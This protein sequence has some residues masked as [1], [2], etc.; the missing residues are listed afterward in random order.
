MDEP[1]NHLDIEMIE[2]LEEYLTTK[3]MTILL[4]THDRYFLDRVCNQIIELEDGKLY[5]H[6]GNFSLFVEKANREIAE[7][8]E[9]DK[10]KILTVANWNG[11]AECQKPEQQKVNRVWILLKILQK[12]LR[13]R[14]IPINLNSM[15]K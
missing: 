9:L 13:Q 14:K 7:A 2:W 6:N 1:T 5:Q 8:S 10:I 3:N 11:C 12:K 15:L 4:V